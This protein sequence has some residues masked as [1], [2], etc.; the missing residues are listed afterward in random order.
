MVENSILTFFASD[1]DNDDV[2]CALY[3]AAQATSV[4][5]IPG[6]NTC[7]SGGKEEYHGCLTSGGHSSCA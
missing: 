3:R 1:S 7:Y 6:E 2:P 4:I 5:M